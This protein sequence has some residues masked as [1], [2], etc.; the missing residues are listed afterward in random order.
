MNSIRVLL[1]HYPHLLTESPTLLTRKEMVRYGM[2][3][4]THP[5]F[6]KA[7]RMMWIWI[8]VIMPIDWWIFRESNFH[9]YLPFNGYPDCG[10]YV[11]FRLWF[12]LQGQ[13][14]LTE[15]RANP[16]IVWRQRKL[17]ISWFNWRKW[18][19]TIRGA[20]FSNFSNFCLSEAY[21]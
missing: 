20:S 8:V 3:C 7:N 17:E 1:F 12:L 21:T 6:L 5:H 13:P 16:S 2:N 15:F 19:A 18:A 10:S 11:L 14:L 4:S 9:Y